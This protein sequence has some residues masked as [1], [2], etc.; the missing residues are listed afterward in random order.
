MERSVFRVEGIVHNSHR[1]HANTE[2]FYR[3]FDTASIKKMKSGA[4]VHIFWS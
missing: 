3:Q 2:D 1:A 4:E